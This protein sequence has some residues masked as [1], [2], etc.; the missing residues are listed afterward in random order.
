VIDDPIPG[1]KWQLSQSILAETERMNQLA[2]AQMLGIDEAR[3]SNLGNGRLD[4]F[5]LQKLIRL[6][7]KMNRR[8]DL[9]VVTVGPLPR[10]RLNEHLVASRGLKGQEQGRMSGSLQK[11]L[12]KTGKRFL[13]N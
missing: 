10:R 1:L 4:R 5:S 2:A 13:K 8:V 3:M 12:A 6:S 9:T 11:P 7:A